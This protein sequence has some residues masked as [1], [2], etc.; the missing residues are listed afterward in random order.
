M[1]AWRW[2]RAPEACSRRRRIVGDWW[3]FA[4]TLLAQA[5]LSLRLIRANTAFNDEAL[6]LW[7]GHLEWAH[8]LHGTGIPPFPT[9]FSGAPVIYPPLGALADSMGGLTGARI[10]SLCFM[11]GASTLLWATTR[12]LYGQRAAF[13][14]TGL[15]VALG[16]TQRL[17]AFATYDAMALFLVALSAWCATGGRGRREATRWMLAG[18]CALVLAN[19]TKYATALFDPVVVG[20]AL[21]TGYPPGGKVAKRRAAYLLAVTIAAIVALIEIGR[22]WYLAGID[23]TTLV[24]QGDG[25][26]VLM[27]L[28]SAWN[29]TAVVIVL[30]MLAVA[31]S[32]KTKNRL[33]GG[34]WNFLPARRFSCRSSRHAFTPTRR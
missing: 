31:A 3:P 27:V 5:A 20:L 8:W 23:Q 11:L 30:S 24:R 14:A 21:L 6:Y 33:P 32:I 17:G 9:Y 16:P 13:F 26:S 28:R 18:A 7:A 29:W 12:R 34:C 25:T 22:G 15:W 2:G 10:L 1:S 4:V 19:A